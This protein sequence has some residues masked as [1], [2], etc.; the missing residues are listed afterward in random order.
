MANKFYVDTSIWRDYF[1]DRKDN[2]KPLGEFAF[3]FLKKCKEHNYTIIIT[4][5]VIKE[6]LIDYSIEKINLAF[7]SFKKETIFVES[8]ETQK[9]E[10]RDFWIKSGKKFPIM[11]ILHSITAR[12][13]NAVLTSRD[14]HFK[15]INIVESLAPEETD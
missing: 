13:N 10:A 6:L 7:S 4:N 12:D 14:H 2:M 5:E 1:E 11:D 15:E 8:T 9:F 3:Q